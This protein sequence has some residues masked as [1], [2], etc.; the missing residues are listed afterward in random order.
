MS[1]LSQDDDSHNLQ[2]TA[3]SPRETKV[4]LQNS[5]KL[6]TF[7][8]SGILKSPMPSTLLSR[9][10]RQV[11]RAIPARFTPQCHCG[12][13]RRIIQSTADRDPYTLTST[14]RAITT[15]AGSRMTGPA[16]IKPQPQRQAIRTRAGGMDVMPA[17][18]LDQIAG[19]AFGVRRLCWSVRLICMASHQVARH[20]HLQQADW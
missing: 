13:Q 17:W 19:L 3:V 9:C 15:T 5:T 18:T 11:Y 16:I 20:G 6:T 12:S 10:S 1:R 7:T 14:S 8:V 4:S 2:A